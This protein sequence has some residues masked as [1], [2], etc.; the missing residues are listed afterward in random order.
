MSKNTIFQIYVTDEGVG[1]RQHSWAEFRGF[2][3]QELKMRDALPFNST[4]HVLFDKAGNGN[5]II[6]LIPSKFVEE[7]EKNKLREAFKQ[8]A[9]NK[10]LYGETNTPVPV[11]N[12]ET[13]VKITDVL[14]T[15]ARL[16]FK[17]QTRIDKLKT[18]LGNLVEAI[19]LRPYSKKTKFHIRDDVAFQRAV[20]ALED[21]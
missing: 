21:A 2:S 3:N 5:D 19:R 14:N 11:N 12:E 4:Y 1:I 20:D 13:Q 18:A 9:K 17:Q 7:R 15:L 8:H 6:L 10:K 16:T